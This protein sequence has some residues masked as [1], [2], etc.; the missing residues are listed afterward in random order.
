MTDQFE[1]RTALV[2]GATSGIGRATVLRLLA[3]GAKVVATGRRTDRLDALEKEAGTDRLKTAQLDMMDLDAVDGFPATL[4]EDW[5]PDILINNAGLALGLSG[6]AEAELSHWDQMIATNVTGLVHLTRGFLPRLKSLPRAD[7]IN[8]S[9]VAGSY[10]YPGGNAYGA[11]KAFVTQFSLNL[12]ADLLGAKVR[13]TSVEPG[14]TDTE[15]SLV[16]FEGDKGKAD[17]VY[18]GADSMTGDD[19]ARVIT[20]VLALPAHINVNR[21][22]LMPVDQAFGPFAVHREG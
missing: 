22:E 8:I 12:R 5:Q 16:R 19:I 1:N 3:G 4:S 20:D 21:I 14:M 7:V 13:V 9:S 17:K 2:T 15:F 18:E 11:T 6:A 10:P